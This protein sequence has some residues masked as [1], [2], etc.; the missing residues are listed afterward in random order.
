MHTHGW[1][2][3]AMVTLFDLQVAVMQR[4]TRQCAD[5]GREEDSKQ[6]TWM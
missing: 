6:S 3:D 2:T 4:E 5:K 1:C